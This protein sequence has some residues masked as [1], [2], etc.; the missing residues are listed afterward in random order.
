MTCLSD[1]S[2]EFGLVYGEEPI[3]Q[4]AFCQMA[5]HNATCWTNLLRAEEEAG[6]KQ[7]KLNLFD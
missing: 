6:D 1:D 5:A 7:L 2:I 4:L 3:K